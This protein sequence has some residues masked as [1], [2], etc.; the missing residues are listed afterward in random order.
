MEALRPSPAASAQA[1]RSPVI[2]AVYLEPLDRRREPTGPTAPRFR[3]DPG[4]YCGLINETLREL[5]V[6]PHPNKSSFG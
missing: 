4:N 6:E 2:A 5:P 1:A 3:V